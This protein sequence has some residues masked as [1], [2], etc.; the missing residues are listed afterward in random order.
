M[1]KFLVT[2]HGLCDAPGPWYLKVKELLEKADARKS[3]FDDTIFSWYH[4]DK[5]EGIL[6]CR[7]DDFVSQSKR[8]WYLKVKELLGKAEARK[9]KF[10]DAIFSWYHNDKLEGTLICHIDDFNFILSRKS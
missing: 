9:S 4:N 8:P 1:W 10:D 7:I 5:L 3:K 6:I 2:I